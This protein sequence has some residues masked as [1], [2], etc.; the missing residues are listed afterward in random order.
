M[1]ACKTYPKPPSKTSGVIAGLRKR[2][3]T[4]A[5]RCQV[6]GPVSGSARLEKAA[7]VT[8]GSSVV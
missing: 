1:E 7:V 3:L 5:C 2:C 6:E 8:G 4:C